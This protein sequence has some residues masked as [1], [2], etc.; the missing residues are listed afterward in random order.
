[1]A[2]FQCG[3][4]GLSEEYLSNKLFVNGLKIMWVISLR[5]SQLNL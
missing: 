2:L 5:D 4:G 1:M 3:L